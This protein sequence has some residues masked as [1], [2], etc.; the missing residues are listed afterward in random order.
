MAATADG[1]RSTPSDLV[2]RLP[3]SKL[4]PQHYAARA[5]QDTLVVHHAFVQHDALGPNDTESQAMT[6]CEG[7]VF[8]ASSPIQIGA[9]SFMHW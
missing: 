1:D 8:T 5:Q 4:M 2:V 6:E 3:R 7:H 9:G